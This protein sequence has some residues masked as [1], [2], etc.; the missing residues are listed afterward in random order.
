MSRGT[1][2]IFS[3]FGIKSISRVNIEDF[4]IINFTR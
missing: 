2:Y 3:N 1:K 4:E